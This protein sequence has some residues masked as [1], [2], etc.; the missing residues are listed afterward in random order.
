MNTEE[1]SIIAISN[2]SSEYFPDNTLTDF[3]NQLPSSFLWRKNG[4]YRY[5]IAVEAIGLS[6][7]FSS[8]KLPYKTENPSVVMGVPIKWPKVLL[9]SPTILDNPEPIQS[10]CIGIDTMPLNCNTSVLNPHFDPIINSIPGSYGLNYFFIEYENMTLDKYL[11]FFRNLVEQSNGNLTFKYNESSSTIEIKSVGKFNDTEGIYSGMHSVTQLF[12]HKAMLENIELVIKSKPQPFTPEFAAY[13]EHLTIFN[14][15]Y[16]INGEEYERIFLHNQL[17]HIEL[18]LENVNK[19]HYPNIVKIKCEQIK[20]QIFDT[21]C[22]KDLIIFHPEIPNTD[23]FFFHEVEKKQYLPLEN[24]IL[25]T[26]EFKLVDEND[27]QI[28]LNE[29]ISTV[30]K[31]RLK[32]MSYYKKSFTVRLTSRPTNL[33][34]K[35]TS[36]EFTVELPQTLTFDETWKVSVSNINLPNVFSSVPPQNYIQLVW[37]NEEQTKK[38]VVYTFENVNFTKETLLAHINNWFDQISP[39]DKLIHLEEIL[40]S[41]A[42]E[43]TVSINVFKEGAILQVTRDVAHILGYGAEDFTKKN[44]IFIKNFFTGKFKTGKNFETV[45]MSYP[46]NM[47]FFQPSYAMLYTDIVKPT[48]VGG[49]YA[50]ILKIFPIFKKSDNYVIHQFRDPEHYALQNNEIKNISLVFKNHAGETLNFASKNIVIVDLTFSNY[51]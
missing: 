33:Y 23:T 35:N 38:R 41:G 28:N 27:V 44:D 36:G 3:K 12:F 39:N 9:N 51:I 6:T 1:V 18:K 11:K 14:W 4:V 47:E 16:T 10:S 25:K 19:K 50:N 32:K 15:D 20:S 29:G 21:Q 22:S 45:Q 43:N 26:L 48:I 2:G 46:M 8:T 13:R 5:H 31:L 42:Y 49:G 34:P 40:V 30:I 37:K 24:T 17:Q 7:N